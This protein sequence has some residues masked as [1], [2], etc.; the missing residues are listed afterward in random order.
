MTIRDEVAIANQTLWEEEVQKGCGYTIP[1]LDLDPAVLKQYAL[2]EVDD[3]PEHL[4]DVYPAHILR[5]VGDKDVLCLAA[6]GGQQSAIF[7]LLGAR[8]TVVD[9]AEGQLMG[10]QRAA[11]HYGYHVTTLHA[12]MRDL[13]C[14]EENAFDLVYQV[15][16][17]AYIPSVRQVYTEVAGVLRPGG[18]YR[19]K[20]SQ[21]ALFVTEWDGAAYRIAKPYTERI[22]RRADGG[23]EFRHYLD[24]IF[25]SLLDAGFVLQRVYEAPYFRQSSP[26]ALPGS[27]EHERLYLGGE[28]VI[29]AKKL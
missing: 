21:P 13:S 20:H 16:S 27:W 19:I 7:G 6:G 29:I 14:L 12:D 10:D 23:I 8:V 18:L 3:V 2:G 28:F 25:N 1:W 15:E 4:I 9:L 17:L 11:A 5:E 24:D 22:H 26:D